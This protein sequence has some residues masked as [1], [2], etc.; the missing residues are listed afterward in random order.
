[1]I[2]KTNERVKGDLNFEVLYCYIQIE[3]DRMK[4]NS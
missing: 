2:P 4:S 1:M 3:N